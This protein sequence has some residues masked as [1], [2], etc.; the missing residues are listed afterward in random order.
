MANKNISKNKTFFLRNEKISG[1]FR[2]DKSV[3]T[4]IP[5]FIPPVALFSFF[6]RPDS[7][8]RNDNRPGNKRCG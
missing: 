6:P 7:Y 1:Q 2:R 4:S 3:W 8:H 5:T